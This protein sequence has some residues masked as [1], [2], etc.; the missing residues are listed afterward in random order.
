MKEIKMYSETVKATHTGSFML[1]GFE[2]EDFVAITWYE[3]DRRC[4]TFST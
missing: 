1:K 2:A 3:S 4:V